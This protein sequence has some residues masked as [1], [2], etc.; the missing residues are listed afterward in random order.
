MGIAVGPD[1]SLYVGDTERGAIWHIRYTGA[2]EQFDTLQLAKMEARKTLN[3]IRTPDRQR[4]NL[5]RD[6]G[7]RGELVYTTYC[8]P[9]HQL[10]GKGDGTRFP[11]LA[12]TDWVTGDKERLINV[13]L[14]G[15]EGA[16]EVNDKTFNT[17]MPQHSFLKDEEIADVL[18]YIRSNFGNAAGEISTEEVAALR[19]MPDKVSD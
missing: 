10:D 18:T 7:V 16:I 14:H 1:G 5:R 13:L 8:T 17:A 12:G 3:H 9:C 11:T 2:R 19:A 6:S 4:D 15:L